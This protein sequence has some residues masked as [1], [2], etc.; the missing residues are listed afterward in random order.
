MIALALVIRRWGEYA[1]VRPGREM[2][3]SRLD[4]EAKYKAKSFIDVPVYRLADYAGAQAK[5]AIEALGT[6]PVA[7]ALVGAGV[8]AAWAL[9]GWLLGRRYDQGAS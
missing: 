6:S 9:N 4:T 5:V 8:G 2:L 1:F 3:F 7:V